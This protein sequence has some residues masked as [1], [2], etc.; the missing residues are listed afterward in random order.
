MAAERPI[1]VVE[2]DDALRETLADQLA[3]D[4]EFVATC[5]ASIEQAEAK[6][7]QKDAHFDVVVLDITLP[8]G[9]GR[10]LCARLRKKGHRMPIIMLTGS[11][12]AVDVVRGFDAGAN[13][14]VTK[15]F[16]LTELLA[17]LRAQMRSFENS[18]DA[19][20]TIGPYTFRP[21][22]KLLQDPV[23]NRRIRLT[24]KETGILK[25][26]YRA[27]NR[28]VARQ[29]LLTEVWG[30]NVAVSTHTLETHI[31]RLR[32]KIEPDPANTLLLITDR[33][34]YRLDPDGTSVPQTKVSVQAERSGTAVSAAVA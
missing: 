12:D 17:R 33:D 11:A 28:T 8:D 29:V 5:V 16:R 10:E 34:G 13:D 25:L 1:L 9:D 21:S 32:R 3:E 7:V 2:D 24:A 22:A 18:E 4:G 23:K 30:Y 31:Y 20:F 15:P 14:Y 27:G 6:L 26:L 19:V